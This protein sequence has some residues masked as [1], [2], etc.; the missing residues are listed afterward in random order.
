MENRT[1]FSLEKMEFENEN[2]GF[3][4]IFH[5]KIEKKDEK[6]S[7]KKKYEEKRCLLLIFL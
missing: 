7:E 4:A 2:R 5:Q 3:R 6:N 1:F